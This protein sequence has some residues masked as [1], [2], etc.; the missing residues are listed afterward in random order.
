[1]SEELFGRFFA[2]LEGGDIGTL[3]EIYAPDAVIWRGR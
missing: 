1:M 2:A 3:R